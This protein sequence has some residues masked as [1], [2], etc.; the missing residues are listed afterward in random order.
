MKHFLKSG[1]HRAMLFDI[2]NT[3]YRDDEYVQHQADVLVRRLGEVRSITFA[4]ADELVKR[5][6][7]EVMRETGEHLSLGNT[8]ARLGIPIQESVAWREELID[9]AQF[10]APDEELS[11]L[12]GTFAGTYRLAALTNNPALTG[13]RGL[14]ALAIDRWFPSVIG[15]D[16]AMASKPDWGP[17]EAALRAVECSVSEVIMV[18]DRYEVDLEPIIDRGGSGILVESREDLFAI[19]ALL[20]DA[21]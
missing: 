9:P 4:D 20:A 16:T 1:P 12:L 10:L 14:E 13:R 3:L 5:T 6:R 18:G 2:D 15:L 11:T 21:R 19:P 17:F 7:D 8:F